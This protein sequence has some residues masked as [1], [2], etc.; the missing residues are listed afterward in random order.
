VRSADAAAVALTPLGTFG[1]YRMLKD[2][3]RHLPVVGEL[4]GADASGL[5]SVLYDEYT[6]DTA[7]KELALWRD[8]QPLHEQADDGL[9]EALRRTPFEER[10]YGMLR[11]L[12]DALP[13]ADAEAFARSLRADPLLGALALGLLLETG[14]ES[15]DEQTPEEM[16]AAMVGTLAA[17]TASLGP[18][19]LIEQLQR[20]EPELQEALVDALADTPHPKS[21]ELLDAIATH[22]PDRRVAKR[23]RKNR[24]KVMN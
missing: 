16:A 8:A 20:M 15:P 5:L 21:F 14:L 17:L 11:M 9:R 24:I 22:H 7:A 1:V 10:R 3:G 2:L 13:D 4:T 18:E 12:F 6:P 23:A 19:G